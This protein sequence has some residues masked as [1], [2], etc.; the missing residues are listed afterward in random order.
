LKARISISL[1]L[2]VL[3]T[4]DKNRGIANRSAFVNYLL[5]KGLKTYAANQAKKRG[6]VPCLDATATKN[7]AD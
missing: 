6:D 1:D 4:V 2:E 5:K 7:C 3:N